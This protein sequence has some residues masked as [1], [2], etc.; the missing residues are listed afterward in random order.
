VA[1]ATVQLLDS[2]R[3]GVNTDDNGLFVMDALPPGVARFSVS[4]P[5]Y[6]PAE[7]QVDVPAMGGDVALYCHVDPAPRFGFISGSVVDNE[8][9]PLSGA[10]VELM[11]PATRELTTNAEG[12]F[13]AP[14]LPPGTYRIRVDA[15]GFLL[16]MTEEQV[17][18]G[19]TSMPRIVLTPKAR[20]SLVKVE[21]AEIVITQQVNF[22]LNS[23]E[24]GGSSDALLTEIADVLNRYEY[25]QLVEIQG[26]TDNKGNH[27][28]NVQLSQARAESVRHRLIQSG[29]A[30]E[31]LEARGYGP[32]VPLVPNKGEA[33]R[34]KNR[35]VQF[36]IK[37]QNL[38]SPEE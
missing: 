14:D 12:A 9:R 30:A 17:V 38:Q 36:M 31:R 20:K 4:H 34:A 27:D 3:A 2:T 28:Y 25:I 18:A 37:Q 7:C 10:K 19:E 15:D 23:A 5:D 26:H 29:I 16:S 6:H 22:K 11:G 13:A 8:D 33:A 1:S 24:I 21:R 35:R 32:D